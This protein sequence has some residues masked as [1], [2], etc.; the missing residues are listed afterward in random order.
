MLSNPFYM[1]KT[2]IFWIVNG[3][4][5]FPRC[6]NLACNSKFINRN[7]ESLSK[8]YPGHCSHAC[9]GNDPTVK[10][11]AK[12]TCLSKYGTISPGKNKD[13]QA[14]ARKTCKE[15]YG[16]EYTF[17]SADIQAKSKKTCLEKYGVEHPAMLKDVVEKIEKT[18]KDRYGDNQPWHSKESL[19]KRKTSWISKYGIDHPSKLKEVQEKIKHTTKMHCGAD[20][21]SKTNEFKFKRAKMSYENIILKDE[22]DSPMFSLEDY[23]ARKSNKELLRFKCKKCGQIFETIH[24][25]G[26][27]LHC[28][29][30]YPTKKLFSA[31]EKEVVDFL[32]SICKCE[33]QE[34]TKDVI[35][36]LELDAYIPSKMLAIEFDGLFWHSDY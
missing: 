6:E 20:H 35:S 8:G 3:L 17:Q 23:A 4:V 36:P 26:H 12:N 18:K 27:H 10:E 19:E 22:Y 5:D 31:E 24:R 16:V 21:F 34:N 30:C 15:K 32:R 1:L 2:K 25:N 11:H 14:K 28:P 33:I 13:V 7:V 9:A 29:S